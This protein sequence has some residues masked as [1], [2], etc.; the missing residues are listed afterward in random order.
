M[1]CISGRENM[2]EGKVL[3]QDTSRS[4]WICTENAECEQEENLSY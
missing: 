1:Q 3:Y 4:G 2:V